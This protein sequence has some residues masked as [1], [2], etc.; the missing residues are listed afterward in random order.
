[1]FQHPTVPLGIEVF[2]GV[3]DDRLPSDIRKGDD[4]TV[5][6]IDG[7]IR[8][9][10]GNPA[11]KSVWIVVFGFGNQIANGNLVC[12]V[13][14]FIR[15]ICNGLAAGESRNQRFGNVIE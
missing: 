3:C 9:E 14:R 4:V 6:G 2:D 8:G 13:Q 10:F 1:M 7:R 5:F 15:I 12:A 11:K